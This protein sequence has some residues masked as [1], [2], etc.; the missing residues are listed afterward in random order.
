MWKKYK[1][2]GRLHLKF[3]K[4]GSFRSLIN[5]YYL[6]HIERKKEAKERRKESKKEAGREKERWGKENEPL[7]VPK[8]REKWKP[9]HPDLSSNH[10]YLWGWGW[11]CGAICLFLQ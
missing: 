7:Q 10:R 1:R 2:V 3:T 5:Q 11:V 8:P 6:N 4:G 9:E